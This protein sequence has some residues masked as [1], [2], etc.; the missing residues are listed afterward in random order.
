MNTTICAA[1][2][3]LTAT[4]LL[5]TSMSSQA[6]GLPMSSSTP[7]TSVDRSFAASPKDCDNVQW[8]QSA[9]QSFPSIASACQALEQR[10][11]KTYVKLAGEVENVRNSGK[12]IRVDFKD[13]GTLTFRPTPNTALYMDGKR[14][15]FTQVKDGTELNFYIPEDRLQ[16]EVQPDPTRVSFLI[17][18]IAMRASDG[19][20]GNGMAMNGRREL[21]RTAG[22]LP[23]L[24]LG[25]GLSLLAGGIATLR[26]KLIV[27][28]S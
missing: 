16:A 27:R 8:S 23:L 12:Q 18:P 10:N 7:D 15:P 28:K 24:A 25:G 19:T 3:P 20:Q 22:P 2:L 21:P 14:T 1:L 17:F 6:A 5:A 4:A 13:G 9:L 26:R 11:G